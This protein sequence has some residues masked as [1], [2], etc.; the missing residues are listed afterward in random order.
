MERSCTVHSG[1]AGGGRRRAGGWVEGQLVEVN[2]GVARGVLI[3]VLESKEKSSQ[4]GGRGGPGDRG[5]GCGP[6]TS[7]QRLQG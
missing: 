1:S 7:Q 5:C 3:G 2:E 4:S 6:T